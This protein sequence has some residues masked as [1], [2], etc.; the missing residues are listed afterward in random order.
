M[1]TFA[2][3]PNTVSTPGTATSRFHSIPEILGLVCESLPSKD[4]RTARSLDKTWYWPA[5][6]EVFRRGGL[7]LEDLCL[8]NNDTRV[9]QLP[10][11]DPKLGY[12][13]ELQDL[14][15]YIKEVS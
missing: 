10:G 7:S 4:L 3:P 13:R 14:P 6:H 9:E 5:T 15:P 12:V 11:H 2:S 1:S 8:V